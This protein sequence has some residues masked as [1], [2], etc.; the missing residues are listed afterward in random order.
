MRS[1]FD[2]VGFDGRPVVHSREEPKGLPF[3]KKWHSDRSDLLPIEASARGMNL[4]SVEVEDEGDPYV[5][6][7]RWG[8]ILYQWPD[9]YTPPFV[10]VFEVSRRFL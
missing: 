4:V 8:R 3:G 9:D 7:D 10:E 6:Y 5:I 1:S 2:L